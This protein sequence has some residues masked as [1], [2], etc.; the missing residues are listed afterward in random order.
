MDGQLPYAK[1]DPMPAT[2]GRG[3][4]R[5]LGAPGTPGAPD[6]PRAPRA[7]CLPHGP[8]APGVPRSGRAQSVP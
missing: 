5:V 8:A 7:P 2:P 4:P 6:A 1:A 3:A